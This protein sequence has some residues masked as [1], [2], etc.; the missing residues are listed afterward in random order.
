MHVCQE[1]RGNVVAGLAFVRWWGFYG[2]YY[3]QSRWDFG[4]ILQQSLWKYALPQRRNGGGGRKRTGLGQEI[5]LWEI[6]VIMG[7]HWLLIPLEGEALTT[8]G[9]TATC[10]HLLWNFM[11]G[12]YQAKV[13]LPI[14]Q[15]AVKGPIRRACLLLFHGLTCPCKGQNVLLVALLP[16]IHPVPSSM[17]DSFSLS[18]TQYGIIDADI[19]SL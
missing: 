12:P 9:N 2:P 15:S 10:K 3:S 4:L 7:L 11:K 1:S 19:P 5:I 18:F 8:A 16:Y 6:S 17:Y 13:S 14:S